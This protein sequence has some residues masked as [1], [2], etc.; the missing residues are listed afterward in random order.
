MPDRK[1]TANLSLILGYDPRYE[2]GS[3]SDSITSSDRTRVEPPRGR[4]PPS[5]LHSK[6]SLSKQS[7]SLSPAAAQRYP[8]R[9]LDALAAAS[10]SSSTQRAAQVPEPVPL[11]DSIS[12]DRFFRAYYEPDLKKLS[13]DWHHR[14][15]REHE[16]DRAARQEPT[17]SLTKL[18]EKS[19]RLAAKARLA[20]VVRRGDC[21]PLEMP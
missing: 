7:A 16:Y 4:H 2:R 3:R 6:Q 5:H 17:G 20:N 19:R 8:L 13:D 18:R 10:R 21:L 11:R 14:L 15:A 9:G 12:E 1:G